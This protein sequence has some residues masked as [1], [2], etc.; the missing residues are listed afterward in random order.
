MLVG[1]TCLSS[2]QHVEVVAVVQPI[3][4]VYLSAAPKEESAAAKEKNHHD[5]DQER[6]RVHAAGWYQRFLD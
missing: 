3:H 4:R 6:V 1:N 5:D 2:A